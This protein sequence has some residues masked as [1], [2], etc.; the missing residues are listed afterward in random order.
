MAG[1]IMQKQ[2]AAAGQFVGP[3]QGG[4]FRIVTT[5][6][7]VTAAASGLP[8]G[9]PDADTTGATSQCSIDLPGKVVELRLN[10]GITHTYRGDLRVTLISPAGKEFPVFFPAADGRDDIVV[11]GFHVRAAAGQIAAGVW[12]LQVVDV[13]AVDVGT[14]SNW[15]L[16]IKAE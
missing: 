6:S 13:A 12:K 11:N 14:L 5:G 1:I 2:N 9:I 16:T 4:S 3:V 15:S 7:Y 10:L 8:I